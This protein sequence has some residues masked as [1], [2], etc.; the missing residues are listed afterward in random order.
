MSYLW[1]LWKGLWVYSAWSYENDLFFKQGHDTKTRPP[2]L[3]Y[4][5]TGN[6]VNFTSLHLTD[7]IQ[8]PHNMFDL[9]AQPQKPTISP[10]WPE[11]MRPLFWWKNTKLHLFDTLASLPRSASASSFSLLQLHARAPLTVQSCP[12]IFHSHAA[13]WRRTFH[14]QLW[15]P[16]KSIY[17]PFKVTA[18]LP[19][20]WAGGDG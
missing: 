5:A 3:A 16:V 12:Y 11:Q 18:K 14:R 15:C 20:G 6:A 1:F 9:L 19:G 8:T 17:L 2:R 13:W 10:H 4:Y 7:W